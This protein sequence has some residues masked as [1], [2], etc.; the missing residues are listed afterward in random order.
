[1]FDS[2]EKIIGAQAH[3]ENDHA[4]HA[5]TNNS[6]DHANNG[7]EHKNNGPE[8]IDNDHHFDRCSELVFDAAIEDK[9]GVHYFFKGE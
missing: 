7:A 2:D 1:M 6:P 8:H 4:D 9:D 3:S 5:H